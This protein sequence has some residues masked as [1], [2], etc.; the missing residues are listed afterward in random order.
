MLEGYCASC[1]EKAD[2]LP[3]PQCGYNGKPPE[4]KAI[5]PQGV[6][7]NNKYIIGRKL[8][9]GG[10]GITYLAY[11]EKLQ[12]KVCIKEYYPDAVSTRQVNSYQ[13][14]PYTGNNFA[15]FDFGKGKFLEE[16]RTLAKFNSVP[17]IASVYDFFE[18]N[19]TAYLVMEYLDGITLSRMLRNN[20]K[21]KLT[22][23]EAREIAI[24]T[25]TVLC[26]VH[27]Q[28]IIHRDI[29]PDNIFMTRES[30]V[31]LLDFGAARHAM[32]EKS[33]SLSVI[34]KKGFAP[35]E[36]YT[37]KGKQGPWTDMYALAATIYKTITGQTPPEAMD[38]MMGEQME[39][40]KELG[41]IVSDDM[42]EAIMIGMDI[43]YKNRL[44]SMD[45]FRK[46]MIFNKQ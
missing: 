41:A 4:D 9:R 46:I 39:S 36:Q 43:D 13:I 32:G 42:N 2:K 18:E 33:Q 20:P 25:A 8:G 12:L 19:G 10:F 35:P 17:N 40:P 24:P 14:S 45:L 6:V 26:K 7:L 22:W 38:R 16:A 27:D 44:K 31:K 11:D 34:L 21:G 1:F 5:L 23:E 29:A 30:D 28:G 3:C 15:D 37:S